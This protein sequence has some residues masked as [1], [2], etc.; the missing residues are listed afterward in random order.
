MVSF[1]LQ[2]YSGKGL[3]AINDL[4]MRGSFVAKN[5][6]IDKFHKLMSFSQGGREPKKSAIKNR[7]TKNESTEILPKGVFVCLSN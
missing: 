4:S 3:S 1:K 7:S 5:V 2:R 6:P